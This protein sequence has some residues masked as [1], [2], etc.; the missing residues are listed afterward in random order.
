[1]SDTIKVIVSA[2]GGAIVSGIFG[3]WLQKLKN[4]G[5]NESVYAEHTDSLWDRLDKI[6]DE[7]DEL[8]EQVIRL[9]AK[10]DEQSKIIDQLTRQMSTLNTKFQDWE[11][12]N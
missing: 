7:R 8:K 1:M 10:I 2:I 4:T 12:E 5:S 6:T 9:N 11:S 3:V